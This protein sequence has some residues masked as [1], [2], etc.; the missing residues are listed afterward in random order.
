MVGPGESWR[1]G[2]GGTRLGRPS[3]STA[4]ANGLCIFAA[5]DAAGGADRGKSSAGAAE[6]TG[7]AAAGVR[8]CGA[9]VA[10]CG[11]V[12]WNEGLRS[13]AFAGVWQGSVCGCCFCWGCCVAFAA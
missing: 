8:V 4:T 9:G 13:L 12:N 6:E 1:L 5:G 10:G 2:G 3:L 11:V 7:E